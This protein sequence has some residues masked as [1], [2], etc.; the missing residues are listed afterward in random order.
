VAIAAAAKLAAFSS[1]I[2]VLLNEWYPERTAAQQRPRWAFHGFDYGAA[3]EQ[4]DDMRIS[5]TP[6]DLEFGAQMRGIFAAFVYGNSSGF[7]LDTWRIRTVDFDP[8]FPARV[9]TNVVS[10]S[11]G[12]SVAVANYKA[13]VCKLWS[14]MGFDERFWWIN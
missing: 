8:A 1:S 3:F 14:R 7:G 2:Y 12:G 9:I 11:G 5:P 4:W 6:R 13:D 10:T